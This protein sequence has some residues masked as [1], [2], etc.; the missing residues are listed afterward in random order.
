[1][2]AV[3][4]TDNGYDYDLLVI[5]SGP[6]G[7]KAAIQAAKL[8]RRAAVVERQQLGG[9]SVNRGTIPSKTLRE[10]IVYLTGFSQRAMYGESYRVKNEITVDDLRLRTR[11]VIDREV[12]VVRHQLMRNHVELIEGSACFLEPHTISVSGFDNRRLTA[13]YVVIATGTRPARPLAVEFDDRTI[14]D[15]D[16]LLQLD[17]IP[18][19]V[20]VVGAGV[21]GIE[22]ASMFAALG[23]KVTVVEKRARLLDFCDAQISEGLQYHL[24]DLGVVFRFGDGVTAVDRQDA[25]AL[26]HLASGKRIAA[27]VVLYTAGRQGQTDDLDLGKVGLEVDKRG[28]IRVGPDYRTDIAHIYAAGDVIGWPA[29]A[30]TSMEQ[31]RLAAAHAFGV[32]SAS[33]SEVLPI[34]IYTIPEISYVGRT[35][36]ELSEAAIPYEVGV[37]RYREL[38]RG[39]ILGDT[40]GMLK[41]LVSPDDGRILG[42]HVLGTN[43]TEVVH[44]GQAVMSFEG[45]IDYFVD[46]VFN[47]PTLAESYK[48]AALD[49][50]N[51]LLA[52]ERLA[53]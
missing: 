16:G 31:G 11:Q 48:V 5:G 23:A 9:A 51:K 50:K 45:T 2:S 43:A 6:A 12:D 38:A 33:M 3:E 15:S 7:Q 35:E 36:E 14:L 40:Y 46:A 13:E 17:R 22:Y 8:G 18:A 49:A 41:L 10:A 21:I 27:D 30:A 28:Q 32:E 53:R 47:Y 1:M 20:V 39:Q 42:V 24:R 4:S 44:I 29:L 52:I 19:S 34:G 37:S 25:G 26:A